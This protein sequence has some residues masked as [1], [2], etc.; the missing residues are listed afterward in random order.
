MFAPHELSPRLRNLAAGAIHRAWEWITAVGA[1]GPDD[2]HGR[3]FRS[4]GHHSMIAF[5]PGAVFGQRWIAIGDEVLIGPHVSMSV[6]M[7]NEP[8]DPDD[9]PVVRIGDRCNIGRGSSLVGRASIVIE[10]DVTTG[11]GVYITDHNHAY[12]DPFTPI[13][14]Q[15]PISAPVRIGA[16]SWLGAGVIVLPGS[17]IGANVAVA[18]GSVVR[19][20]IPDRTVVAGVPATVVRRWTDA[21]WDPPIP[22]HEAPPPSWPRGW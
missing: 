10:D 18:G 15:Y 21:G 1:V 12:D 13:T 22:E 9:P 19:G 20:R 7:W 16:G 4:F 3:R 6:G 11:P 17:D 5:P 8:R 14:R 2:V